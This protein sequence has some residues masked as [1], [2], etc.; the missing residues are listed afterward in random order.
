MATGDTDI[1]REMRL[2]ARENLAAAFLLLE[3]GL[4]RAAASRLYFSMF[5]AAVC[6]LERRGAKPP[7]RDRY[8]SHDLVLRLAQSIRGDVQDEVRLRDLRKMRISG[9]YQ[10]WEFER[11]HLERVRNDV[12]RFVEEVTA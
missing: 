6:A 2:A 9:D 12:R 3:R 5:Q 7:S 11:R 4:L 1:A 10:V 8:W